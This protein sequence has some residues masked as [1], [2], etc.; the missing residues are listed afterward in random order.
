MHILLTHFN[1]I[2]AQNTCNHNFNDLPKID[3]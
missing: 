3:A 2:N 1:F